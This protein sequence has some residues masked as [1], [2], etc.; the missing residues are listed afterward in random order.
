MGESL[1]GGVDVDSSTVSNWMG[2]SDCVLMGG[3]GSAETVSSGT[4][5]GEGAG[6]GGRLPCID[7]V[8]DSAE[9]T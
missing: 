8:R 6:D 2:M 5:T 3:G 7:G 9:G 4:G 1:G